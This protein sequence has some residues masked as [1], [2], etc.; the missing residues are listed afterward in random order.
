MGAWSLPHGIVFVLDSLSATMLVL[1]SALALAALLYASQGWDER[2]KNFHALFQF[3]LMGLN[4]AFLTGDIF[5]LFVFFE[6]LLIAS[7]GLLLHGGGANRLKAG[8]HYVIVNLVGSALFVIALALVY[9]GAGTLNMADLARKLAEASSSE[10]VVLT[11]AGLLLLLVFAIKG[12]A[13]PLQ[14]WLPGAYASA[15]AP[16]ACLFAIMTKVGLYAIL[17]VHGLV[18]GLDSALIGKYAPWLLIIGGAITLAVGAAG[19]IASQRLKDLLA[20]LVISSVGTAMIAIGHVGVDALSAALYYIV[21][22]TLITGAMFLLAEIIANQRGAANDR[23][24][25]GPPLLQPSL[26]GGLFLLGAATMAGLPPTSGFIG[27]VGILAAAA[28]TPY[29]SAFVF[30]IVLGGG[31]LTLVTLS[32]AGSVLFWN[33]EPAATDLHEEAT[34]IGRTATLGELSA[35][36]LLLG[37]TIALSAGAGPMFEHTRSV[38]A[39]SLDTPAYIDEVLSAS[40]G[41]HGHH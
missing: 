28:Q 38:A 22:S 3:Q 2:G 34:P 37:L 30:A 9:G 14:F 31:L 40:W 12:A 32:R 16:V 7:Y 24:I 23:L 6:I 33:V 11:A 1:L 5:N 29:T 27:K 13:V 4:G 8:L 35:V 19:A 15:A 10:G 20:W 36:G 41:T 25:P 17:R 26:L 18:W 39:A 21:H